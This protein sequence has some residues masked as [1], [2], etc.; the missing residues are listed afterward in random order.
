MGSSSWLPRTEWLLFEEHIRMLIGFSFSSN[1][2]WFGFLLVVSLTIAVQFLARFGL[3][4]FKF[5]NADLKAAGL[6]RRRN[7]EWLTAH[8][9][10]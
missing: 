6:N 2:F 5:T 8:L 4:R 7:R 3:K 10:K 1:L 9:L